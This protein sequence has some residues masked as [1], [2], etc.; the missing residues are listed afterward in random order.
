MSEHSINFKFFYPTSVHAK[1]Q[2]SYVNS[3]EIFWEVII[4]CS[5]PLFFSLLLIF[6]FYTIVCQL[7]Y[8]PNRITIT[9]YNTLF[10]S[11]KLQ[12]LLNILLNFIL[13]L[14]ITVTLNIL[15]LFILNWK[16]NI[17]MHLCSSKNDIRLSSKAYHRFI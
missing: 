10:M 7:S 11:I 2:R 13:S 9:S 5:L 16:W 8:T 1:Y 6:L 14:L 15:T 4:F 17:N 3:V 12:V